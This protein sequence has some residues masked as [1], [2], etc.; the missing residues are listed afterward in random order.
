MSIASRIISKVKHD[1]SFDG[2][3]LAGKARGLV[4]LLLALALAGIA[5][6]SSPPRQASPTAAASSNHP[7]VGQIWSSETNSYLDAD[8]LAAAVAEAD[9]LLLGEVHDNPKHHQLQAWLVAGF[10]GGPQS[11]SVG[12]EQIDSDQAAPLARHLQQDP[13]NALDLGDAIGWSASGWPDWSLY[14]PVFQRVLDRGWQPVPLMFSRHQSKDLLETGWAA[15]LDANALEAL[16]P[17]TALSPAQRA[18]VEELMRSSHCDRLPEEYLPQ[19][20]TIQTAKDAY[21]AWEQAQSGPRG[22]LIVGDGHARKDRG[23]PLFLRK[24][25]PE[26][27]IVVVSMVEVVPDLNFP[28]DYRQ[29]LPS[30]SDYVI[31]TQRQ[32]RGDPCATI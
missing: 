4:P 28:A 17:E 10:A 11:V 20:V 2:C 12:F 21:M 6:C 18:E 27:T 14:A 9:Y 31:F 3:P 7:L 24:L 16:Q 8:E 23:I 32:E 30:Y 1:A 22:I 26:A 19:M 5:A 13:G 25:Q 15:V 29:T